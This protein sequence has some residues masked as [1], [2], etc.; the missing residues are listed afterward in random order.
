MLAGRNPQVSALSRCVPEDFYLVEFRSVNKLVDASEQADQW[1]THVFNQAVQEAQTQLVD[2]RLR[3]QLAVEV[4]PL[5][6][7]F[8]DSVV[9]EVAL[10]GSDLFLRVGSDVA[11]LFQV[12]Q[13]ALFRAQMDQ[14]L[15]S[16]QK[17]HTDAQRTSGSYLGVEFEH[18]A[19]PDRRI[20]VF[21]AYPK[22]N[23]HVR[24]NSR[25]ALERILEA[26]QGKNAAGQPVRRLGDSTEFKYIRTL[27]QR[28]TDEEDG[29]VYLSD[30][31]VRRLMG[32]TLRLTNHHRMRCYNHLKMIGHAALM[33]RTEHGANPASL[34]AL[35]AAGC[36]PGTFGEA[37]LACPDGG[38]YSLTDDGL[39]GRCSHHGHAGYLNPC[40]EV[41]VDEVTAAEAEA[42]R[43]FLSQY[44]SYWR[45][46]FDPI[47]IRL[48]VS[49]ERIRAE[50]I[51][52]PLI[53]NSIYT[54]LAT[55]LG[56]PTEPLDSL[57]VPKR[58]IFSVAARVNKQA[59]LQRAGLGDVLD[60]PPAEVIP[61]NILAD[62]A[63]AIMSLRRIAFAM[64]QHENTHRSL[65]PAAIVDD[66]NKPLLS[67]RVHLLPMLGE[68]TLYRQ[69]R[70]NE[71]WDSVHNRRLITAMPDV[72]R[73]KN[74]E[75]AAA[76]KTTYLTPRG[77]DTVFP[78]DNKPTRLSRIIDGTSNTIL[79]VEADERHA[80]IW[81]KPD[82]LAAETIMPD[83]DLTIRP[84]GVLVASFADGSTHVIRSE[85]DGAA[86]AAL[87]T[88]SGGEAAEWR[89]FD[90][91]DVMQAPR[92]TIVGVPIA[93]AQRLGLKDLLT[94][95]I[96]NQVGF[97][98]Y[99]SEP[100]FDLNMSRFLGMG[101]GTFRGDGGFDEEILGIAAVVGSLNSPV[102]LSLPVQ[103]DQIVDQFLT[104]LDAYVAEQARRPAEGFFFSVEQ[105]FY[106]MPI[107]GNGPQVRGYGVR[108]GP[109]KWRFFWA[110]IGKAVYIA[111]KPEILHD[112]AAIQSADNE[113]PGA[114][115][116]AAH[117]LIRVRPQNWNRVLDNYRLGWE[118]NHRVACLNNLGPLS[119]LA[120]ALAAA[121]DGAAEPVTD[122]RLQEMTA[123]LC[124][125]H[126]FCPDGGHYRL[127]PD[128]KAVTGTI[129]GA[130]HAPRQPAT[131]A[132]SGAVDRLMREFADLHVALSF[133][134]DGLHAV[135]N[136]ERLPP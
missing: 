86:L 107:E 89:R 125:A 112:L 132:E 47:A 120:R 102:Y 101:I 128:G 32:P 4:N 51:V 129:H 60:A 61:P 130:A 123:R 18:V 43:Q 90:V 53:D 7:P 2:K 85:I 111:S 98:V 114:A 9:S 56:G 17:H 22:P 68:E 75:L 31:F 26:V 84:P 24:A 8:Y 34:E 135:V 110:R 64:L 38:Q 72:F 45:T 127:G 35:T 118:E 76:G 82:D 67:W 113:V 36:A 109:M 69:F 12:E 66:D 58:N 122:Q 48:K 33:Y 119:S 40:C 29:F 1:S 133:L 73:P 103:D 81:T 104:R 20:H 134:E 6:K 92:P 79:L 74:A 71:P 55:F 77:T 106:Q 88:R 62:R 93:A 63:R 57:P 41:E 117:A 78:P 94:K 131:P 136:I 115:S 121:P 3:E 99:D 87:F 70:L 23:L 13:P 5:L 10:T 100:L 14:F 49:P 25:A 108:L 95:G 65:P 37:H 15:T 52:L 91:P 39:T 97:H 96:G 46:F 19:T 42:Y 11:L 50:T 54:G 21:S 30:P 80:V 44:N 126:Y 116:P 16:A 27:M 124:D 28:G 105:D 59:V 83:R